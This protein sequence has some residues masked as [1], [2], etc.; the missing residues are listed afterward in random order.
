[1]KIIRRTE[2]QRRRSIGSSASIFNIY[3]NLASPYN[4]ELSSKKH[5]AIRRVSG[6]KDDILSFQCTVH[7]RFCAFPMILTTIVIPHY[8]NRDIAFRE[9]TLGPLEVLSVAFEFRILSFILSKS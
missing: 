1:M 7:T 9:V 8:Y 5:C 3:T 2:K 6:C 4:S